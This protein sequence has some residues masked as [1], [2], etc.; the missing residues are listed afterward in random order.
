MYMPYR[1]DGGHI[2]PIRYV[3]HAPSSWMVSKWLHTHFSAYVS[4]FQPLLPQI[5]WSRA[6]VMLKRVWSLPLQRSSWHCSWLQLDLVMTSWRFWWYWDTYHSK[7]S[8][9]TRVPPSWRGRDR[10]CVAVWG[11][12]PYQGRAEVWVIRG[13]R[14]QDDD[15]WILRE[16]ETN[17]RQTHCVK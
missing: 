16:R 6:A 11:S 2:L 14:R 12:L 17:R 4:W 10:G 7:I 15:W 3:R 1:G 8:M 13:D 5:R 9:P